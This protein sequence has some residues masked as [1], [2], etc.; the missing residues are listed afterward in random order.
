MDMAAEDS[1]TTVANQALTTAIQLI[2]TNGIDETYLPPEP[3][4]L[5]SGYVRMKLSAQFV[6]SRLKK[7]FY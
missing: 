5:Q 4:L 7:V 2:S 3:F 6:F 1:G